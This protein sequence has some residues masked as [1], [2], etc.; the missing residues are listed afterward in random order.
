MV[1]ITDVEILDKTDNEHMTDGFTKPTE[2]IYSNENLEIKTNE[3]HEENITNDIKNYE[4]ESL[5]NAKYKANITLS[6]R[7]I[8]KFKTE[9][10]SIG[11]Y[12]Y[13][14]TTKDLHFD[15]PINI[16]VNLIKK[17]GE[18]EESS[19][20]AKCIL[21]K[22]VF[23]SEAYSAPAEFKCE[24]S[25]IPGNEYYSLRYNNSEYISGIPN[26]EYA[27]N[28][29]LTEEKINK[30]E[31]IDYS[32]E[33][34]SMIITPV[35]SYDIISMPPTIDNYIFSFNGTLSGAL[36]PQIN[37]NFTM[38]LSYPIGVTFSCWFDKVDTGFNNATISCISDRNLK[39]VSVII[40]QNI[41]RKN[42]KD[43]FSLK[44]INEHFDECSS[45][46]LI[47]AVERLN[48]SHAF[49]EVSDYKFSK[50]SYSLNF[51]L[52]T[53]SS[54]MADKNYSLNINMTITFKNESF[55][56]KKAN[57]S[58]IDYINKTNDFLFY[59]NEYRCYLFLGELSNSEEI[60][61]NN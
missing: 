36:P 50:I 40:E 51:K 55:F 37:T 22:S 17:S 56:D 18:K 6:F 33:N 25:Y 12:L 5:Q 16:S 46:K 13:C 30:G 59:E 38:P 44:S 58:L 26:D 14:I 20:I 23:I 11:F 45:G 24:I 31:F 2:S 1:E 28:P 8:N 29:K 34:N 21:I 4:D 19:R 43:Y 27:L 57:C 35:F 49:K 7:Q 53:I 9:E 39:N 41:I 42:D 15:A 10:N 54:Q 47:Q 3:F 52:Y 60:D 48:I 61:F 32:L